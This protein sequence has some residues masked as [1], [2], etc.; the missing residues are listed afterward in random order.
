[1]TKLTDGKI[2]VVDDMQEIR[3]LVRRILMKR[4]FQVIEAANGK[5]AIA[6]VKEHEDLLLVFLDIM[7][8]DM[9]GYD[10]MK[11]IQPLQE[12]HDFKVCFLSGKKEKD[13]VVKAIESGGD[14]Y[15]VKPIYPENLLSKVGL[16]LKNIDLIEGFN[17]LKC[18]IRAKILYQTIV[19]DV[20]VRGIDELSVL[21]FST[22]EIKPETKLELE[23]PR[24]SEL[25]DS[26]GFF[27]LKVNKCKRQATGKY[28]VR[29]RFVGLPEAVAKKIR[30]LAIRGEFIS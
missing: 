17:H 20:E 25:L 18:K 1:M 26:E 21:L 9:E 3:L 23:S 29:C 7:L 30:T 15:I 6:A 2:L 13:A 22:A 8:P 16:L 24:L 14:D 11:A 19:P 4:G 12:K 5:D 10:V 27:S 28:F